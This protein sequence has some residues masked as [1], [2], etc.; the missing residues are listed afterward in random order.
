MLP[1]DLENY[2]IQC[3]NQHLPFD[4]VAEK[5]TQAGWNADIILSAKTWYLGNTEKPQNP[6]NSTKIQN[7]QIFTTP[8]ALDHYPRN[9]LHPIIWIFLF[10][11]LSVIS[12]IILSTF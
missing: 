4:A 2:L 7:T 6:E 9:R 1:T 8:A 3:R 10:I 11:V 12:F 5:L